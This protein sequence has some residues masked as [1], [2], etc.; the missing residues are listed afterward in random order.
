MTSY[1]TARNKIIIPW[2][3]ID[4]LQANLMLIKI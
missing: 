1:I 4:Q 3:K 2:S